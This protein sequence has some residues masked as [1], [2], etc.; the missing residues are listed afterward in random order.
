MPNTNLNTQNTLTQDAQKGKLTSWTWKNVQPHNQRQKIQ[1]R[2][3]QLLPIKSG[4]PFKQP[5]CW[6]WA[7]V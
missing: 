6:K 2:R 5:E 7:M 4:K 1:T 3:P